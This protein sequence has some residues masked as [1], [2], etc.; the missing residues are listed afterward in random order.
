MSS[1]KAH[2]ANYLLFQP[3]DPEAF[4][5][6]AGVCTVFAGRHIALIEGP[7]GRIEALEQAYEKQDMRVLRYG[8]HKQMLQEFGARTMFD[9]VNECSFLDSLINAQ[10]IGVEA[11]LE[12][13]ED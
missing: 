13:E 12:G 1:N 7:A 4:E 8:S 2:A 11:H 5:L 10:W 9:A 6:P 3:H